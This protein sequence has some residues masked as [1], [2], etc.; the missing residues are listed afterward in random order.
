MAFVSITAFA[1][2][3]EGVTPLLSSPLSGIPAWN[4]PISSI[5]LRSEVNTAVNNSL[6]PKSLLNHEISPVGIS[7][8]NNFLFY[9]PPLAWNLIF[10]QIP[11]GYFPGSAPLWLVISENIFRYAAMGYSALLPVN[12]KHDLFLSGLAVYTVGMLSYFASWL[13]LS[14]LPDSPAA[15]SLVL[16]LAPAYLPLVWL[17]G[18]S[19][20]AESP[21][22]MVLSTLFVGFHVTDFATR[23]AP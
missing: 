18:M 1:D 23:Y 10:Q 14:Y 2:S 22:L 5:L 7:L 15:Q 19:M 4:T 3:M 20:M 17:G 13:V 21:L 6:S 9:V 11:M 16:R 8:V 12:T